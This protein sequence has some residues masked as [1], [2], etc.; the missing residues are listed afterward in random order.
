[1]QAADETQ[2]GSA[3]ILVYL[4]RRMVLHLEHD[5]RR[6]LAREAAV[7]ARGHGAHLR[8]VMLIFLDAGA[9]R[10]GD[11]DKGEAA[12]PLR[13]GLE[14][15]LDGAE[16]LDDALGVVE[17]IDTDAELVFGRQVVQLAYAAA[18]VRHA[19]LQH[20]RF[21]R[22][23]D[24]NRVAAHGGDLA[25]EGDGEGFPVDPR[26]EKTIPRIDEIVAVELGM[27]AENA[28]AQQ[29]GD[30]FVAPGADGEGL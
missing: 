5:G 18:A 23:R 29:S 19:L 2:I 25:A 30:D 28:A 7:D 17:A 14:Q 21:R 1:M 26:F 22:P 12:D 15:A 16:A 27:K 3:E 9:R 11:L 20:L 6:P 4:A 8:F 24:R 10:R 13:I